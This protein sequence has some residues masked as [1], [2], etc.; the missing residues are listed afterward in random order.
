MDPNLIVTCRAADLQATIAEAQ[1]AAVARILSQVK[2]LQI[3]GYYSTV[4]FQA[5]RSGV[6]PN[7]TFTIPKGQRIAFGYANGE[8]PSIAGFSAAVPNADLS[9]TNLTDKGKTRG[10]ETYRILGIGAYLSS[11]SDAAIAS[12]VWQNAAATLSMDAGSI[13]QFGR[14]DFIPAQAGLEGIG[15]TKFQLPALN[16]SVATIE[17]MSNGRQFRE[18]VFSFP[19]DSPM[20]WRNSGNTD[21]NMSFSVNLPADIV[22]PFTERPGAAGIA[23]WLAPFAPSSSTDTAAPE[24]YT[25]ADITFRMIGYSLST[26]SVNR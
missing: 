17:K 9:L 22:I 24:P 1:E 25:F 10:G 20:I 13:W 16:A 3:T 12:A 23:P 11:W 18:N 14:L 2:S 26:P 21:S 5:Y 7:F 8:S 6:S 4:R 19:A 15:L